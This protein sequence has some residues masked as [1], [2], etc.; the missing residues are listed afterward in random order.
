MAFERYDL[1]YTLFCSFYKPTSL[2]YGSNI[3]MDENKNLNQAIHS[4]R[5]E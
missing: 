2:F 3:F 5:K 4:T 1:K